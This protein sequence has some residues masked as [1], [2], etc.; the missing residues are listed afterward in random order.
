MLLAPLLGPPLYKNVLDVFVTNYRILLSGRP[1]RFPWR[2]QRF[3]Y[4][5]YYRGTAS[6]MRVQRPSKPQLSKQSGV[7][8]MAVGLQASDG[9]N[10]ASQISSS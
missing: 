7:P 2:S 1:R 10:G 3:T 6:N 5:E 8:G 9:S 4:L